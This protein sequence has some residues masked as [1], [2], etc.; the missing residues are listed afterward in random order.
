MPCLLE[1]DVEGINKFPC[2]SCAESGNPR[3][4]TFEVS[5]IDDWKIIE[6]LTEVELF[7]TLSSS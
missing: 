5:I 1:M 7:N 4:A 2:Q 6:H 3:A